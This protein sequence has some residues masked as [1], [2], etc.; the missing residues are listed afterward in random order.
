MMGVIC[1]EMV[2]EQKQVQRKDLRV[3]KPTWLDAARGTRTFY[4]Q[5]G[6]DKRALGPAL[7]TKPSREAHGRG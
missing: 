4:S 3:T 2:W 5:N 1:M 6:G 7:D